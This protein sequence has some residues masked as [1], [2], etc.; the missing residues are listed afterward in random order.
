MYGYTSFNTGLPET[1]HYETG[2]ER[3]QVPLWEDPQA[4]IRNSTVY[5][6][7]S[8]QSPLLL[9]EGDA[10]GNV[11]YWQS[12]ELYNFGRRLGK[13]VVFLI[14]NDENHGVARPESQLDY[15]RR[16]LEWFAHYLKGEPPADWI[17]HGETY[18]ARQKMLNAYK[19]S[20]EQPRIA[21][22][23]AGTGRPPR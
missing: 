5:A 21:P 14:Y 11:N 6:V 23:Q 8:L 18:L 20:A 1:G 3:M 16:Q 12:M 19:A 17:V 13:E 10:D 15:H 22:V 2:Q 4:Y 7:D 9:E